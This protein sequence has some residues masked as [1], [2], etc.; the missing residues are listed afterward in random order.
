MQSLSLGPPTSQTTCNP[1]ECDI[2][3]DEKT[4]TKALDAIIVAIGI[5]AVLITNVAYFGYITPPGGEDAYWV[6]CRYVMFVLYIFFN[7]FAMVFS[8]AAIAVVTFGPAYLVHVREFLRWRRQVVNVGL[9]LL[10]LSLLTLLA[11]FACAGLIVA[12]VGRPPYNCGYVS[13]EDGGHNCV[14][15]TSPASGAWGFNLDPQVQYLNR[16]TLFKSSL[17]GND[18]TNSS[19]TCCN[20]NYVS[21]GSAPW[22]GFAVS[23][24]NAESP[25]QGS[26]FVLV[27]MDYVLSNAS[28]LLDIAPITTARNGYTTW[29]INKA[30]DCSVPISFHH[31]FDLYSIL[32][33]S[34]KPPSDDTN[35]PHDYWATYGEHYNLSTQ[36]T[37]LP[38]CKV[39]P[40]LAK[41]AIVAMP[42]DGQKQSLHFAELLPV[43]LSS[44]ISSSRSTRNDN[45]T[46]YLEALGASGPY[47]VEQCQSKTTSY[48]RLPS[49]IGPSSLAGLLL[50]CRPLWQWHNYADLRYRCH[51]IDGEINTLCDYGDPQG[52]TLERPLAVD[53]KGSYLTKKDLFSGSPNIFVSQFVNPKRW[54]PLQWGVIFIMCVAFSAIACSFVLLAHSTLLEYIGHTFRRAYRLL[55][56]SLMH[57]IH[58]MKAM[59]RHQAA[60]P[61]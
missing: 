13:C 54:I 58:K 43:S 24:Q 55:R 5:V 21:D 45:V 11:A 3:E 28:Q 18:S 49:S 17:T 6:E 53:E 50:G 1:S 37:D 60:A 9:G 25:A 4:V 30:V 26:C 39:Q 35:A 36:G 52:P 16:E 56:L 51:H 48:S 38:A 23:S 31:A 8:T 7:G 22:K 15:D 14:L 61:T 34:L 2:T 40:E 20:F 29:C 42:L 44:H 10:F 19:L 47:E 33:S 32:D 59:I 46:N 12:L 41:Q 57:F 27:S